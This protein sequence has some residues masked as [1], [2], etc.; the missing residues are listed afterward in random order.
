MCGARSVRVAE[1][2]AGVCRE[3]H[4]GLR[5]TGG[6]LPQGPRG[7]T[8]GWRTF[9]AWSVRVNEGLAEVCGRVDKGLERVCRGFRE[10]L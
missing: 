10:R 5:G 4:E 3:L 6:C 2:L 7:S 9:A 1:G 8:R